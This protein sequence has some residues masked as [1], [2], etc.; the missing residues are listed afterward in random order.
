MP[1]EK[2]HVRGPRKSMPP[3]LRMLIHKR[4]GGKCQ[5]CGTPTKLFTSSLAFDPT[6]ASIDHIKPYSKGG[7]EDPAN[8]QLLCML[9]NSRKSTKWESA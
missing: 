6:R 4:D 2:L 8:L 7:T 3:R 5:M 9:C 1:D